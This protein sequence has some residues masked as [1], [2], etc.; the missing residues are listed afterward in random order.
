LAGAASRLAVLLI[1]HICPICSLVAPCQ[2]R[3]HGWWSL[4]ERDAEGSGI[5]GCL[6]RH[7]AGRR[8]N[9]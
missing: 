7:S 1:V 9:L 8:V 5:G 3:R 6:S 4:A 2:H